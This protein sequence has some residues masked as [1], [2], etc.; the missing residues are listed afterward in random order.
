MA[1]SVSSNQ[2]STSHSTPLASNLKHSIFFAKLV[3]RSAFGGSTWVLDTSASDH[4]ACSVSLFQSYIAVS[5]CVVELPNG[6]SA[7][8]TH[9]GTV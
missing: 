8:V 4:I 3:N 9:I 7:H 1:N 5:H 6:E 2:A